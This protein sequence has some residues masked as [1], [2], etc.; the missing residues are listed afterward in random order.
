MSVGLGSLLY[1]YCPKLRLIQR[2]GLDPKEK[3]RAWVKTLSTISEIVRTTWPQEI[4]AK[5][6]PF[7]IRQFDFYAGPDEYEPMESDGGT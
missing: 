1:W 6:E 7:D 2:C 5:M 3:R 4:V